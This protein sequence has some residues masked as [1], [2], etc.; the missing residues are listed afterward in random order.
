MQRFAGHMGISVSVYSDRFQAEA[1]KAGVELVEKTA[2]G[3][4]LLIGGETTVKVTSEGTGGRNLE[5]VLGALDSL[6][7]KTILA[8]FASDGWDNCQLA[9]ALGDAGTLAKSRSLNL[10]PRV[11]LNRN[12]S[13][14]FFNKVGDGIETGRLASNV[15]DLMIVYMP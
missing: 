7:S 12:D 2:K 15:S 11:F 4:I 5:V 8:S 13:L 14:I 1:R 6:D 9:G 10:D 3:S